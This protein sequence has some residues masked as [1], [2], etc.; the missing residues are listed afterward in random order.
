M[1]QILP[2]PRK[3]CH[4]QVSPAPAPAIR[5]TLALGCSSIVC[6]HDYPE[7]NSAASSIAFMI[8]PA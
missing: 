7:G 5:G 2:V 1:M 3:A 4:A 8:G 6:S